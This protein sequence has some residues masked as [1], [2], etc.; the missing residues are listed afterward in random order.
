MSLAKAKVVVG[1]GRGVGSADGFAIIE[2][3]AGLLNAAVGL[4]ARLD[5]GRWLPHTDQV[6]RTGT[7][8]SPTST[9][10]AASAEPPST[11]AGCKGAKKSSRSTP[12]PRRPS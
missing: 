9:S 12:T 11:I 8:V 4:L 10:R 5:H 1:G 3:L 6:G 7:K 2:E